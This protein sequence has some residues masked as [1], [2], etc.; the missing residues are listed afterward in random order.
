LI[1]FTHREEMTLHRIGLA[2]AA[3]NMNLFHKLGREWTLDA[4]K[5]GDLITRFAHRKR[6]KEFS[7]TNDN[8]LRKLLYNKIGFPVTFRTP[9]TKVPKVDKLALKAFKPEDRGD[10]LLI[11]QLMHFNEVDKLASGWYESKKSKRK[12]LKELI[13]LHPRDKYMGLLHNWIY[14][15]KARTGRRTSGGEDEESNTES[16][17]SQNWSPKARRI[18][19]SRWK[20]GKIAVVDFRKLEP[21]ITSWVIGD[22]ELLDMFLNR[23]GYIDLAEDFLGKKV[24]E[25]TRD[26][27]SIKSTWLALTY[28]MK[29][30]L[31][32]KR[33]WYVLD[34][35]LADNWDRHVKRTGKLIKRFFRRYP[36]VKRYIKK[37]IHTL[38]LKQQ[39]VAPDGAIRHLPHDGPETPLYWHLENQAVNYPIQRMASS[40]TG[41]GMI[42]YEAALLKEH[43]ISY[44][45]WHY[46]LLRHP[47]DLPCS[48]LINEVH[49]ELDLDLH[50]KTGKRDLE[51]MVHCATEAKS[52][53]AFVPEFDIELK[54]KVTVGETWT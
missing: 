8:D 13:E 9:T 14:A 31:F 23:G 51:L 37:Q 17:N 44:A 15:L 48:P 50:P 5:T 6:M 24:K 29:K 38:E 32:A 39:V 19:R 7:P 46:A 25:G 2:G 28:N 12:S 43:K 20:K 26:Y 34:V 47:F 11:T 52:L 22:D 27:I 49:D 41:S 10:A 16:R 3:V 21:C 18:I 4:K 36:K 1:E 54:V 35:K 30:S 45:D 40:V 33:L 42:D 53:R